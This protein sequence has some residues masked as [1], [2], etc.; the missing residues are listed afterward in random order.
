MLVDSSMPARQQAIQNRQIRV[1]SKVPSFVSNFNNICCRSQDTAARRVP[2]YSRELPKNER[3]IPLLALPS[4]DIISYAVAHLKSEEGK[5]KKQI[6]ED[7]FELD[8]FQNLLFKNISTSFL[9]DSLNRIEPNEKL[10]LKAIGEEFVTSFE[11]YLGT[12][13]SA[14]D[15]MPVMTACLLVAH[16]CLEGKDLN[17]FKEIVNHKVDQLSVDCAVQGVFAAAFFAIKEYIKK[18]ASL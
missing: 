14:D 16:E 11:N 7:L 1:P 9:H 5:T 6:R 3:A 10:D 12:E 17:K 18:G 13:A 15:I 8:L 4:S 2:T